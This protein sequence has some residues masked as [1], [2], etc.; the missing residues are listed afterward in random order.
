MGD[1]HAERLNRLAAVGL[2]VATVMCGVG[3]VSSSSVPDTARLLIAITLAVIGLALS[4]WTM[5]EP[6]RAV[7]DASTPL[8]V[9]AGAA[10]GPVAPLLLVVSGRA[11]AW[12]GATRQTWRLAAANDGVMA[13]KWGLVG[14]VLTLLDGAAATWGAAG[15]V[16]VV[17][18][19]AGAGV[20]VNFPLMAAGVRYLY[21]QWPSREGRWRIDAADWAAA[22]VMGVVAV[23]NPPSG[24]G[25]A[26]LL[27]LG[28]T[29][30]RRVATRWRAHVE[31][32]FLEVQAAIVAAEQTGACPGHTM[33]VVETVDRLSLDRP[34]AERRALIRAAWLHALAYGDTGR[35]CNGVNLDPELSYAAKSIALLGLADRKRLLPS[36]GFLS[37]REH[38][39][40]Q[41]IAAACAHAEQPAAHRGIDRTGYLVFRFGI[42]PKIA[43]KVVACPRPDRN[44]VPDGARSLPGG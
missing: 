15:V 32:I 6:D 29:Q 20:L 4:S 34:P 43:A 40:A 7:W 28:V 1:T 23:V 27:V 12:I 2:A 30:A 11:L 37:H 9:A 41:L 21:G 44:T 39:D 14:L 17:A 38:H 10:A 24:L 19:A 42:T 5:R 8:L 25:L 3:L 26:V 35:V 18:A 16:V 36:G 33:A 22:A 31:S 13:V